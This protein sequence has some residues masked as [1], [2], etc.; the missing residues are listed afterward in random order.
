VSGLTRHPETRAALV[1]GFPLSEV[2]R[3]ERSP[4]PVY[5]YDLDGIE[6]G[7]RDLAEA[8]PMVRSSPA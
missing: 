7:A 1:G 6:G 2:F 5:V 3:L 4:G 8:L